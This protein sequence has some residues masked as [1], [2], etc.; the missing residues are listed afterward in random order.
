MASEKDD[1]TEAPT[2]KR[3]TEARD[4]GQIA[5]SQDLSAA[6]LLVG[7]TVLLG[8]TGGHIVGAMRATLERTLAGTH[9][10]HDARDVAP[11]LT[12]IGLTIGAAMAPLLIGT[13]LLAAAANFVQV[14]FHPSLA[15]LQPKLSVFNPMQGVK[16]LIGGGG[17]RGPV[18]LGMSL[19]KLGLVT[20]IA[21][22]AVTGKIGLIVGVAML[23]P[24]QIFS[25]ASGIVYDITLRIGIVLLVL[26]LIDFG[27]QKYK[28]EQ[29]LKMSKQ[30]VKD[31]MKNSEGDPKI[32]ARRRQIAQQLA[33]KRM[34]TEVPKADVI[35]TNPTHYAI[36]LKYD[37]EKSN[38][39]RVVA[40]GTD[41]VALRIREIAAE[42]GIPII[43]RP[44]LARAIYRLC[45]VGHEIP[46]QFYNAVAE[47]LA[48][49]YELT[50]KSKRKVP[51]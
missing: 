47:I 43:E 33:M 29:D 42:H 26:A 22:T 12:Q 34:A 9:A 46:E 23:E 16:K 50:G 31:E 15:R 40:K 2:A 44:P 7:I 20:F 25:L 1:K 37:P 17:N 14:G 38:A 27:Y 19:M 35:I 45:E 48:Y 51:A 24:M 21:W 39:P 4:K 5:K 11:V 8:M 10:I 30:E 41:L 28:L 49:V 32:K 6:L 36:A 3:R 13:V 18:A